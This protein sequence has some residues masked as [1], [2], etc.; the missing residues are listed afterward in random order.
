VQA[1]EAKVSE[2]Q[3]QVAKQERD[4]AYK[5]EELSNVKSIAREVAE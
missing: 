5:D 2:L 4:I 3:M 1:L